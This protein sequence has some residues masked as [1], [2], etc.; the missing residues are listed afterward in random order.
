MHH[1][2]PEISNFHSHSHSR[3]HTCTHATTS[4]QRADVQSVSRGKT[5]QHQPI[6]ACL[7]GELNNGEHRNVFI[8]DGKKCRFIYSNSCINGN[9]MC[10][11]FV[12]ARVCSCQFSLFIFFILSIFGACVSR[13]FFSKEFSI[14]NKS[15]RYKHQAHTH[16]QTCTLI[17]L[18]RTHFRQNFMPKYLFWFSRAARSMWR[19]YQWVCTWSVPENVSCCLWV[20]LSTSHIAYAVSLVDE[21]ACSFAR[22]PYS[23]SSHLVYFRQKKNNKHTHTRSYTEFT[24]FMEVSL[25]TSIWCVW[26][27]FYA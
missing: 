19:A 24:C 16:Q 1:F 18:I 7:F 20:L 23:T 17:N 13:S 3:S 4:I 26:Q 2:I 25:H 27:A 15:K 11:F 9:V 12:W 8:Y 22:T 10:I 14:Q 5:K 6:S 21:I